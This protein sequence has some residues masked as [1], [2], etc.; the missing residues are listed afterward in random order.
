MLRGLDELL[1]AQ[2][3]DERPRHGLAQFEPVLVPVVHLRLV[4][5]PEVPAVQGVERPEED[6]LRGKVLTPCASS[7]PFYGSVAVATR[8]C[9]VS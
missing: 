8:C 1:L 3:L 7:T 2:L 4:R 6:A 5:G 9:C